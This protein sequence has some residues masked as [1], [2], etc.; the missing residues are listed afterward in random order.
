MDTPQLR[1]ET[2]GDVTVVHLGGT[3]GEPVPADV[4]L[5]GLVDRGA[6][7]LVLDTGATAA[8]RSWFLGQIVHLNQKARAAGCQVRVCCPERELRDVFEVTKLNQLLPVYPNLTD[9]LSGF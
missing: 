1:V 8:V 2:V 4:G 3:A 9:A 7:K 5:V 6:C